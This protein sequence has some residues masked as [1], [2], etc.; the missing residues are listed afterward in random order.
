MRLFLAVSLS[1]SG[2]SAGAAHDKTRSADSAML[3]TGSAAALPVQTQ[4]AATGNKRP[5][6]AFSEEFTAFESLSCAAA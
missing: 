1:P 3:A 5:V 6:K 4:T 2:S